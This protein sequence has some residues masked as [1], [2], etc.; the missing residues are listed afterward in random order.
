AHALL[1][2]KGKG[3]SDWAYS[4]VPVVGPLAGAVLAGLGATVYTA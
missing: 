2:I 3:P 4:W 1:P